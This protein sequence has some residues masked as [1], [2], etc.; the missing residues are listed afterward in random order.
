MAQALE[1]TQCAPPQ[2]R[3]FGGHL[4]ACEYFTADAVQG[5]AE[6]RCDE[7]SFTSLLIT[8]GEGSLACDGET[9]AVRKGDSLFLPAGS[10]EWKLAGGA[11]AL[12]CRVPA[13]QI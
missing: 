1:V 4:A 6:G 12:V 9:L 10:G 11:S 5:S 7:D 8:D 13:A 3:D 2:P